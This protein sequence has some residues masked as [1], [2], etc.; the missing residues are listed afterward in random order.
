M[1]LYMWLMVA[2]I[3][4]NLHVINVEYFFFFNGEQFHAYIY[5]AQLMRFVG[6]QRWEGLRWQNQDMRWLQRE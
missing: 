4:G 5:V 1:D 6:E 2:Q 3:R